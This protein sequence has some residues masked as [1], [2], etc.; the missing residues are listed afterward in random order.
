[1]EGRAALIAVYDKKG[2]AELARGLLELGY[3]IISTGGTARALRRAGVKTRGVSDVTSFPEI[4]GGRVKTLH[5]RIF[6]GILARP[7]SSHRKQLAQRRIKTIDVVVVNLYPFEETAKRRGVSEAEVIEQVDVGGVA[8][9]RAAAK[10]FERVVVLSSPSQYGEA[11]ERLRS[12][13]S[14]V[15]WRRELAGAAFAVT[16]RYD[17]AIADYFHSSVSGSRTL[18]AH[19]LLR[20]EKIENVAYGENPHQR[21]AFYGGVGRTLRQLAG[22][23]PSY[24][25]FLDL[26]AAV[27][28]ANEFDEPACAVV[29]HNSPC[30]VAVAASAA[31]AFR[32]AWAADALSAYGGI[33]A[34]NT[35]VDDD[36]AAAMMAKGIYFHICAGRSYDKGVVEY[37]RG[38][39]GWTERL[40]IF[41]GK[42]VRPR[43]EYRSALGGL[44][45]QEA[46]RRAAARDTWEQVAGP[47]VGAGVRADLEFAWTVAKYARSNAVVIAKDLT[48]LAIGAG[49]VNRLWPAEDA[50]RRAGGAARGAVAASDGFFPK[51]DTPE[52]LCRAGVRAIVQPAGS[53]GDELVVELAREYGVALFF[54]NRRHFRH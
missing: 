45:V 22:P 12:R 14:D 43:L 4:L 1:M 9:L 25:N 18:P 30:G 23:P 47:E 31:A 40:R 20:F 8:L 37:L 16:A 35:A 13:R 41:A 49:A 15:E 29:K 19:L 44:L 7:T 11:L 17:A 39:K 42:Y 51:P 10:N 28:L 3:Q 33:V 6:G 27:D 52:A 50:V 24:N 26:A 34:F 36:A 38:A 21:A 2:A 5:P 53:K 48:S 46:D 54:A 32:R